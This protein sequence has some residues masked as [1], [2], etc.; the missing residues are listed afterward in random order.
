ME[1]NQIIEML[2]QCVDQKM[3]N[4]P[5]HTK[6]LN[7]KQKV[8]G[9]RTPKL[10]EF[11]KY[12]NKNASKEQILALKDEF[13]E[14]TLLVGFV[15]G[16]N[17]NIDESFEQLKKFSK[18]I[19]NWATCDQTCSAHKIFKKDLE[20]KYFEKFVDMSLSDEEFIARVGLIMI[21]IYYLKPECIDKI[22][23][24]LSQITN[25][26]YYVDMAVAWLISY[27]I[28]K[29]PEKT[30]DLLA[31]K[32]LT[33]FVQNRAICKCRDSFRVD[34]QVKEMLIEYRIK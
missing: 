9:V 30:I 19:D 11:A 20:N 5:M 31:Q 17:K 4:D 16:Y 14:E 7:T 13:W 3:A 18:R 24:L 23:V 25:H 8:L 12:V 21:M 2:K 28:V 33:K 34:K 22:F 1:Y 15:L 27:A 26:A 29:F 10:R 6:I 32:K